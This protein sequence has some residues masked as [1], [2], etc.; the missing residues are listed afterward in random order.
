MFNPKRNKTVRIN[1]L[2]SGDVFYV[3]GKVRYSYISKHLEGEALR[4]SIERQ[5][6]LGFRRPIEVPHTELTIEDAHVLMKD[7]RNPTKV[8]TFAKE[9][10]YQATDRETGRTSWRFSEKSLSKHLPKV[11]VRR[12]GDPKVYDEVRL[13][14]E[15][16]NG[17]D[18]TVVVSVYDNKGK[19][20]KKIDTVLINEPLR[21]FRNA[22]VNQP[23]K[24]GKEG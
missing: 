5:K 21:Y 16:A 8:E 3:A 14:H 24:Q 19:L 13:E 18:V 15:P 9:C 12:E 6:A 1:E 17:L 22:A 10:L 23:E 11:L 4:R 2:K 20:C 7:P